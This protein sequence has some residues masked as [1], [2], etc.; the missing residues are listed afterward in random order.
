MVPLDS[1]KIG[2]DEIFKGQQENE[3]YICFFR[4]HWIDILREL[5]Y[6]IIF[7]TLITI[8]IVKI[9]EIQGVLRGNREIKLFFFTGFLGITVFMHRFFIKILNYFINVGIITDR[10]V[11]DHKRSLFFVDS[12]DSIDMAQIQN[13]EKIQ[14]GVLPSI[15]RFGDIKLYL[16]ASDSIKTFHRIPNA[17]FHFREIN[18]KREARQ[19]AL[20]RGLRREQEPPEAQKE[21]KPEQKEIP[22]EKIAQPY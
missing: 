1:L 16:T 17:R 5:I 11:I 20:R 15:L 18:R 7:L 19:R 14:N 10:R 6:F 8:L 2:R 13:I 21:Q 4:H 22:E 12:M 9:G 3:E